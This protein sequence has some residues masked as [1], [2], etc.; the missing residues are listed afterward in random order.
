MAVK[1]EAGEILVG[2][3][4]GTT[5]VAAVVAEVGENGVEVIGVGQQL[6]K[7]SRKGMALNIEQTAVSIREAVHEAEQMAGCRINAVH[8]GI[9]G[10]HVQGMDMS[11]LVAVKG[12]EVTAEDVE[13]VKENARAINLPKDREI[14]HV[15]P[16]EYIIDGQDG[17]HEPVGISGVRLEAKVHIITASALQIQNILKC[18]GLCDLQVDSITLEHIAA[19][20]GVLH[21][22][23][24]ELGVALVD[25]GGTLTNMAIFVDGTL[26]HTAVTGMG[27][28]HI[29]ND[30]R[31]GLRTIEAEAE[32]LKKSHACA[33]GSMVDPEETILVPRVGPRPPEMVPRS[34]LSA[35][36]SPRVEEILSH[37]Q[38]EI[39]KSGYGDMLAGGVVLT[40]GGAMLKGLAEMAEDVMQTMVRV[41]NP[42]GFGGMVDMVQNPSFSVAA[43]LLLMAARRAAH[44]SEDFVLPNKP[45]ERRGRGRRM[46][47]VLKQWF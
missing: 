13:R 11:G 36:V 1:R 15:L 26:R 2:L 24:K 14:L 21:D 45:G 23:E 8:V 19:A 47:E 40:G 38:Q 32:R 20:E 18:C 35:I 22:G 34:A 27:G 17:I 29:T 7:G 4:I 5:K 31:V 41:G 44:A 42:M 43:G 16:Q 46:W 28:A 3:D 33:L 25:V 12:G 10:P 9:S 6:C 39:E 37:V 30:I